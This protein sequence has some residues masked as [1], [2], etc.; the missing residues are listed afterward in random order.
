[1]VVRVEWEEKVVT[2]ESV[3][4]RGMVEQVVLG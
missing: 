2:E 1:M 3:D 4:L